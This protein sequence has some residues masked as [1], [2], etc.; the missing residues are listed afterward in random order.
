M[1]GSGNKPLRNQRGAAVLGLTIALFFF[2]LMM[3]LFTFEACEAQMIQREIVAICD[4]ASLTGTAMLTSADIAND[5]PPSYPLLTTAQQNAATYAQN[6]VLMST[7]LGQPLTN[8][9]NVGSVSSIGAHMTAG[10]CQYVISLAD[11]TNNYASVSAGSIKGKSISCFMGYGYKP[12]LLSAV[13]ISTVATISGSSYGGLPQVDAVLV[14]D[15]SASMDDQTVVTFVRREWIH[16]T[17]HG[18]GNY[19]MGGVVS[20][21]TPGCGIIQYL[22][23]TPPTNP[24]TIANYLGWNY[25]S[26]SGAQGSAVNALPPQNLQATCNDPNGCITN[27]MFFD[28]YLRSHYAVGNSTYAL[29]SYANYPPAFTSTTPIEYAWRA[30]DYST[31]P[32]NCDLAVTLG[33][34]GDGLTNATGGTTAPLLPWA[35]SDLTW[36][37]DAGTTYN[38]E[39]AAPKARTGT[40]TA[41]SPGTAANDTYP[42]SDQQTFTDLVVNIANPST[43]GPSGSGSTSY[44]YEEPLNGPNT[45]VGFSF[46]FS[47]SEPDT[48]LAGNTFNFANLGILVEAARG[49]LELR[50]ASGPLGIQST[51]GPGIRGLVDRPYSINGTVQ[52]TPM[53]GVPNAT[54]VGT[55]SPPYQKAYSRL[56]MMFSQPIC[57]AMLGADQGFYQKLHLLA[58]SCFGFVG[59]SSR[60]SFDNSYSSTTG[61]YNTVGT[62][63]DA[64]ITPTYGSSFYVAYPPYGNLTLSNYA[65]YLGYPTNGKWTTTGNAFTYSQV[66]TNFNSA[67][68]SY[69]S[70]YQVGGNGCNYQEVMGSASPSTTFG[71]RIPRTELAVS[72]PVT[73]DPD[74]YLACTS[75][76]PTGN[77]WSY[78]GTGAN[79]IYNGRPSSVTDTSEALTTARLMF[80]SSLYDMSSSSVALSRPASRKIIVFFTDGEPTGGI[81]GTEATATQAVAGTGSGTCAGDGIAIYT[82]GLNVSDNPTL[83]SDQLTFLG[84]SGNGLAALAGNS[85]QFFPCTSGQDV[86]NAFSA[87]ARRLAQGQR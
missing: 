80:H 22:A 73:T 71:F 52:T 87:V 55:S 54:I 24:P 13:G 36:Q 56:A 31:P 44:P 51:G 32:G 28:M 19:A 59:F 70:N 76:S 58:D 4:A 30:Y 60:G 79:G 65:F 7:V 27:N 75:Q 12:T 47:A 78:L 61:Y 21:T 11:P 50:G 68:V 64:S 69:T 14:F 72:S 84:T 83:T 63:G 25:S 43:S 38:Y 26:T 5:T 20:A 46:T 66:Q 67:T 77:C 74:Q 16:D 37:S 86:I 17:V 39:P 8:A 1:T 34:N 62:N 41:S 81:T 33:G 10:A 9:T 35:F 42:S 53:Y 82:I 6:M 15:Y 48:T 3:G 18:A 40:G 2:M 49:N 23:L 57:T 29:G 45:F 85:G